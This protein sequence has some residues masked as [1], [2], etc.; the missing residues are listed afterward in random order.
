MAF[1]PNCG[2]QIEDLNFCP[3]CGYSLKGYL[4]RLLLPHLVNCEKLNITEVKET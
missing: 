3:R 4:Y 2:S 1:C